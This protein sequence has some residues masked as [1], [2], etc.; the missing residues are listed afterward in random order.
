MYFLEPIVAVDLALLQVAPGFT[1]DTA[2]V[3][4]TPTN[5]KVLDIATKPK[6]DIFDREIISISEYRHELFEIKASGPKRVK[7]LP[8]QA[9]FRLLFGRDRSRFFAQYYFRNRPRI[10]FN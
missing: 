10:M 6:S 2:S 3:E 5:N 1:F 4:V 7:S 8:I 9:C